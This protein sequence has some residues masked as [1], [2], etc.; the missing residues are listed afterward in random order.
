MSPRLRHQ[1]SRK[2]KI[3]KAAVTA[4]AHYLP[5]DIIPNSYF[6]KFLDTSDEWIRTRTGISE[7]RFLKQGGTSDLITPAVKECLRERGLAP[8]DIDVIIVATVTP[9]QFFPSTAATVQRKA[10]LKNAWGFDLSA[11]CSGYLYA[12][13]TA[14]KMIESGG[15]KRI[16]V[17]GGDKMSSI[18]NPEDRTTYVLFGDGAGVMLL[19]ATED[20]SL[21]LQDAILCMDGAGGDYLYMT[22]G[23]S[24]KPATAETVANKEHYVIQDG[25]SVFKSAV[26]GMAEVSA[27]IMDR[28]NLTADDIAWLVPHQ[29]NLRIIDATANRMGLSKD[30][31]IVNIDKYGNTTAGTIPICI[32]EL[33]HSGRLHKGD[34][35]VLSS[36]GAGFTWGSILLRWTLDAPK[37]E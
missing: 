35:L 15:A 8:E 12:L 11:A 28:N 21:G 7:R 37:S 4:T 16:L 3:M 6:E 1:N 23:G 2:I 14:A 9:D 34:A 26:I 10:G 24:Q 22:A 18:L 27:Q 32:S 31:V 25:K 19:E 30:K 33:Y 29:A 13:F 17:C 5:P 36:F 20:D